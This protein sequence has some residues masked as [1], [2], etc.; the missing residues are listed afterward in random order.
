MLNT[1]KGLFLFQKIQKGFAF[2]SQDDIL[3]DFRIVPHV[4]AADDI[5]N[6]FGQK[7]IILSYNFV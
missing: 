1:R 3:L 6:F 2:Q 4:A 5:G 7:G